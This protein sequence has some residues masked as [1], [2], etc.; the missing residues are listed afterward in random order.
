MPMNVMHVRRVRVSMF[1][2]TVFMPVGMWFAHWVIRSM[3]VLM[4]FVMDMGMRMRRWLVEVFMFMPLRHV[5][6]HT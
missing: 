6:P 4:M 3:L 1:Y 5:Q 2:A